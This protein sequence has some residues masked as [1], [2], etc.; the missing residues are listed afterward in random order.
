M[1]I[2]FLLLITFQFSVLLHANPGK[3]NAFDDTLIVRNKVTIKNT[4]GVVIETYRLKKGEKHGALKIYN[5]QAGLV[6]IEQYKKGKLDGTKTTYDYAGKIQSIEEYTYFPEEQKSLLDGKQQKFVNGILIS[7]V[8]FKKDFKFGPYQYFYND[9]KIKEKGNLEGELKTGKFQAYDSKGQLTRDENYVIIRVEEVKPTKHR[10]VSPSKG[11]EKKEIQRTEVT[12]SVL[13]GT[14]TYYYKGLLQKEANYK[15]GKLDGLVTEYYV[16]PQYLLKSKENYKDNLR[17]GSFIFYHADGKIAKSGKQYQEIKVGDQILKNVSEG[18]IIYYNQNGFIERIENWK[19][20]QKQG[21]WKWFNQNGILR[22][23]VEYDKDLK[24]GK[25]IFWDNQGE[26]ASEVNFIVQ[27]ENGISKSVSHGVQKGWK[28]G[29]L[30]SETPYVNGLRQGLYKEYYPSGNLKEERNFV[31]DSLSGKYFNYFEDGTLQREYYYQS[32]KSGNQIIGWNRNFDKDGKLISAYYGDGLGN[33]MVSK[34]YGNEEMASLSAKDVM[35]LALHPNGEIMSIQ[36]ANSYQY[37]FAFYSTGQLRKIHFYDAAGT[38][39]TANFTAQKELLQVVSNNVIEEDETTNKIARTIAQQVDESW[40]KQPFFT[41]SV[42]NGNYILNYSNGKPFLNL[43]FSDDLPD[44]KW[45]I[46]DAVS[47]DTIFYANFVKGK[48]VGLAV[49]KKNYGI[50]MERKKYGKNEQLISSTTYY[51]NGNPNEERKYEKKNQIYTKEFYE[52]GMVKRISDEIN[53]NYFTYKIDGNVLYSTETF[54]KPDSIRIVKNYFE[55][56]NQ[57]KDSRKINYSLNTGIRET[58]YENGQ[59]NFYSETDAK[60]KQVGTYKRY[61]EKGILILSGSFKEG[62]K[63]GIWFTYDDEGKMLK[64]ED[65]KAGELII[66]PINKEECACYDKSLS[67][68]KLGFAQLASV[69]TSYKDIKNTLPKYI[70]AV[71]SFNFDKVFF[72]NFQGMTDGFCS[73][74]LLPG[75]ELSFYIS[76]SKN[77]RINLTPC[78][79]PGYWNSI[80]SRFTVTR[81]KLVYATLD[82]KRIAISLEN[83]PLTKLDGKPFKAYFDAK[84]LELRDGKLN[85]AFANSQ[86]ECLSTGLIQDFIKVSNAKGKAV[87]SQLSFLDQHINWSNLPVTNTEKDN[88]NGIVI[89]K[90]DINLINEIVTDNLTTKHNLLGYLVGTSDLIIAGDNWL[91]GQ[92][93]FEGTLKEGVFTQDIEKGGAT[94]DLNV[95]IKKLEDRKLLRVTSTY[96]ETEK[97]LKINFFLEK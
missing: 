16:Q 89:Q 8:T 68:S 66:D 52:N 48:K 20:Y 18:E 80:E 15:A 38:P 11:E 34:T 62:K 43:Q 46:S 54:S 74:K 49:R 59:L 5:N 86:N 90:A 26:K 50:P 10:N 7:D 97:V 64:Q 96:S 84:E 39:V 85:L 53:K 21:T 2:I 58:Y 33:N 73:M 47:N 13:D 24:V 65:F 67:N 83:N 87:V 69:F 75:G 70:Q 3:A 71:D 37:G 94:T 95:L 19:N 44:G 60:E 92:L 91:A 88:F 22:H 14:C 30:I 42:K 35:Q 41:D 31:N 23:Q 82:V 12:R 25:E 81:G 17:F 32:S 29:K 9:G 27:I 57:I 4:Q 77:L 76:S 45:L 61:N 72:V 40:G 36:F 51:S 93:L 28:N 55:K 6:R 63:D 79:A 56:S 1:K 78:S